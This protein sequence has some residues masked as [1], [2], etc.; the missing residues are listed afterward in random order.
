MTGD[1]AALTMSTE[2]VFVFSLPRSGSTLTQRVLAAHREIATASEPTILI[3]LLYSL[4]ESGVYTEYWHRGIV[5]AIHDFC[6]QLPNGHADYFDAMRELCLGL[7]EKAGGGRRYFVDKTPRYHVVA[8]PILD[9]FPDAPAIFLWRNPLAVAASMLETWRP[10]NWDPGYFDVDLRL[11]VT[12]LVDAYSANSDRALSV[13]YE[14]LLARGATEWQRLFAYLDLEWEPEVLEGF[15][16]VA[17]PRGDLAGRARYRTGV[18]TEPL[19][20]WKAQMSNPVRKQ[21]CK[22]YLRWIGSERLAVMGFDLPTMLDEVDAIPTSMHS[23]ASDLV[24]VGSGY[25]RKPV[26]R[27]ALQG[28]GEYLGTL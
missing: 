22:R 18:S 3:P 9:L 17:L 25:A 5:Q 4:R 27:L 12:R 6:G 20:K 14:D 21:W 1:V 7:Y 15:E 10:G 11:G 13:R 8:E 28:R 2:P 16:S 19:E 26:R 24:H 23:T